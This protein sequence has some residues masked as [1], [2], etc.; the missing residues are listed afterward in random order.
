MRVRC[1]IALGLG[2]AAACSENSAGP[3]STN[4]KGGGNSQGA[5][6]VTGII[7]GFTAA[8]DSQR[9]ELSGATVTL[10]RVADFPPDTGTVDTP[11]PPPGPD[12]TLTN[13]SVAF[14]LADTVVPPDT[15][16][17]PPTPSCAEGTV[18]ATIVTGTGGE[19]QADGLVEG[20]FNVRVDPPEGS[21][22]RAIEYCG[23]EVRQSQDNQLT[24]YLPFGPGPDPSPNRRQS[25]APF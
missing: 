22:F 19:W 1:A 10:I 8:P 6:S 12:T 11:F 2:L 9:L 25:P 18:V 16:T 4:E 23:Y 3:R 15:A 20:I 7:Y 17:P 5:A 21:Q 13:R 24:L 14:S